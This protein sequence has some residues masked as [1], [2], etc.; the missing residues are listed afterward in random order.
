MLGSRRRREMLAGWLWEMYSR[1][2]REES[3]LRS[4]A[5]IPEADHY[6]VQAIFIGNL[7]AQMTATEHPL[8]R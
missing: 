5:L 6:R 3:R 7:L 2:C 8:V 1:S 4:L